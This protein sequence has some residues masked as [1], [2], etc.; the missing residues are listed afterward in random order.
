MLLQILLWYRRLVDCFCWFFG[1]FSCFFVFIRQSIVTICTW[2]LNF[3]SNSS[4]SSIYMEKFEEGAMTLAKNL[5][6]L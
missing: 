5:L 3:S 2:H 6:P 4:N 1:C